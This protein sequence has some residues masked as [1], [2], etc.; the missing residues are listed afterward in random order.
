[1]HLIMPC[2]RHTSAAKQHDVELRNNIYLKLGMVTLK[3]S[4]RNKLAHVL[5]VLLYG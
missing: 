4:P 3:A 1:M 2:A 5:A